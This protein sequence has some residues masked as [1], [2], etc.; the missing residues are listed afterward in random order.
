MWKLYNPASLM[1][2][3]K[4][5]ALTSETDRRV[6]DIGGDARAM[7]VERSVDVIGVDSRSTVGW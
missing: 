5:S 7:L 3:R 1:A 4:A 2:W 6:E